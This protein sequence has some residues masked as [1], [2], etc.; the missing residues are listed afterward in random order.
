MLGTK[1]KP[2]TSTEKN[3]LNGM[4]GLKESGETCVI[5]EGTII[6]GKFNASENVRIDGTIKGEVKCDKRLVMGEKGK[7]EGIV[8]TNDAIIM[9]TIEGELKANGTLTLKG[10]S[11]IR[12]IITAKFMVVE[13]GARYYGECNI[14]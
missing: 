1:T 3:H 6:D 8:T 5:S 13:E 12:G 11:L 4:N 10:T 14:G 2:K 9:G 7:V